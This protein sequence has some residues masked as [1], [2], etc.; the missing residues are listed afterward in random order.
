MDYENKEPLNH[1]TV[2][3]KGCVLREG[4]KNG[5]AWS[6]IEVHTDQ[7]K[8]TIWVK[9]QDGTPTKAFTQLKAMGFPINKRTGI[10]FDIK[11]GS[12]VNQHT[13]KKVDAKN[14]TIMYFEDREQEYEQG[15]PERQEEEEM[16]DTQEIPETMRE[17]KHDEINLN[18]IPF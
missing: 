9:K 18:E 7:D 5:R 17:E 1:K 11:D 3:L 16:P 2:I 6:K 12:Y 8:Y 13:G 4:E 14:R 15:Q 10:A